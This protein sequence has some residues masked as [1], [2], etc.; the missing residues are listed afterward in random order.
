MV[1]HRHK[2]GQGQISK[3]GVVGQDNVGDVEVDELS[4][5]VFALSEGNREADLPYRGGRTISDS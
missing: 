4:A 2:L 3:D 1:S 5:V